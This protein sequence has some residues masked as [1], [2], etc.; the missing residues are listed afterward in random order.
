MPWLGTRE[1]LVA[2]PK[3][4]TSEG[5]PPSLGPQPLRP[6]DHEEHGSRAG[7]IVSDVCQEPLTVWRHLVERTGPGRIRQL[8]ERDHTTRL[9]PGSRASISAAISVQSGAT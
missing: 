2:S 7:V 3:L 6:I 4:R 9:D 1:P 5:G 8:E